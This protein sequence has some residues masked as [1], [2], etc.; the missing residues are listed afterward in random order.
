MDTKHNSDRTWDLRYLD[1]EQTGKIHYQLSPAELVEEALRKGEGV[2][3]DTGAL[4]V[5]TGHPEP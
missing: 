4:A 3:T 2:L 5:S 1:L